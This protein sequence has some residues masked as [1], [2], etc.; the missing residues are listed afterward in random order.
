MAFQFNH[1]DKFEA[2]IPDGKYEMV[3]KEVIE[4]EAQSGTKFIQFS[5]VVRNDIEQPRQNAVVFHKVWQSKETG[6]YN[7]KTFNT[8]GWAAQMDENKKYK[9]MEEVFAD[10][11]NKPVL[12]RVKNETSEY[13][14]KTYENRN[15]KSWE[16][17]QYPI[18]AHQWK[19][20]TTT[21]QTV[22]IDDED[23]P[24]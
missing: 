6:T 20:G 22:E 17:S 16:I 18:V 5:L 13:N 23:L 11:A 1:N 21:A 7:Q 2:G 24:F 12:V 9:K 8:I 14:G 3:I 4:G 19:D 10:L 15:V